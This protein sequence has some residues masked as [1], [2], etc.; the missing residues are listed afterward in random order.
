M[1][2]YDITLLTESRYENPK[3]INWYINNIIKE[4]SL[5]LNA[6]KDQGLNVTRTDWNNKNFNWNNTKYVLFRTTWDYFDKFKKFK[7]WLEKV[8]LQT[9]LINSYEQIISF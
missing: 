6:L 9:T 4:D 8:K 1:N 7:K 2:K 5:V 3:E